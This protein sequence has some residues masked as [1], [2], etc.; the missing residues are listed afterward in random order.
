MTKTLILAM[1]AVLLMAGTQIASASCVSDAAATRQECLG[2]GARDRGRMAEC[3][4]AYRDDLTEC[5]RYEHEA[6]PHQM[7]PP[8]HREAP[9]RHEPPPPP[10]R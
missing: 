1:G 9:P 3:S 4:A 7:A 2:D 6:M 5:H 10:H 8:P